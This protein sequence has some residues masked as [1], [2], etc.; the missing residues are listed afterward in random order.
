M[1][2]RQ[3]RNL[4]NTF[5]GIILIFSSL[6]LWAQIPSTGSLTPEVIQS[7][8]KSFK[9]DA[10]TKAIMNAVTHN[11]VKK[12]A[13]NRQIIAGYDS[14]FSHRIETGKVTNQQ[15]SGRCWLFAGLNIMRP[16]VQ[17]KLNLKSFEFSENYLFFW[18]KMEKANF[19][20]ESILKT[21]TRNICDREVEFLLKH[22]FPDGGQ[23]NFVVALINKYGVVPKNIM[24]ESQHSN[25]TRVMNGLISRKLRQDAAILRQMSEKGKSKSEL[26]AR[27]TEMLAEIYRMLV[28][29]LGMPPVK[30]QWRYKDKNGN[31]SEPKTYTPLEFFHQVVDISLDDYVCLYNCPA[32]PYN[33]LYQINLDRNMVEH[34]NLTFININ[35]DSLKAVTLRSVL[36]NEPVWFGCDVGKES[37]IARGI[38]TPSIYDY[39]AIYDVD[40]KLNKKDRILY[41]DSVPTHAMVFVGVDLVEGKPVKW[42]VEN[43]WGMKR[44]CKGYLIMFDKWFDDYVYEVV[45]NKKY[46]S[47]SVLA[48]LKTKPIVLPPWDPMY[49]LLE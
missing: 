13:L 20:L 11:D 41:H 9:L 35:I 34:P 28:L 21:R 30:F 16:I 25:N 5:V 26:R 2:T 45:I 49:S 15:K 1:S 27:K 39:E 29:N 48:L 31:L 17:R 14:L 44:G 43:S 42:L 32:H 36:A 38:M 33:K 40:L 46:L 22:P 19:F 23:W 37:Y 47:P 10:H 4:L 3:Q 18:D 24:P 7:L 8:R 12:L 6:S